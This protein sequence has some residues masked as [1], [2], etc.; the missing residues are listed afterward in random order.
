MAVSPTATFEVPTAILRSLGVV[1]N[2]LEQL[3]V[4]GLRP[5]SVHWTVSGCLWAIGGLFTNIPYYP[6]TV[7]SAHQRIQRS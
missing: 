4:T 1:D 7:K 5:P 3:V 6:P 2:R